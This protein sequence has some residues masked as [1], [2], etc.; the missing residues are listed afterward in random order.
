MPARVQKPTS[1]EMPGSGDQPILEARDISKSFPGVKALDRINFQLYEGEIL[2]L[3][4]ENGAGKSTLMKILSG[5]YAPDEGEIIFRGDCLT[6]SNSLEAARAGIGM[7][8]QE[9]SLLPNL[10]VAENIYL[11]RENR[12][13]K[14]GVINWKKMFAAAK[15]RLDQLG[16][17]MN[18]KA[19]THSIPFS[20]RQM[21]EIARVISL[22][23]ELQYKPI[24]ILDEPTTTLSAEEVANLFS[25]MKHLAEIKYS[26]IFISHRLEEVLEVTQK[27]VVLKD[28]RLE[29][30][31]ASTE[32]DTAKLQQLMVGREMQ[33]EYY[34]ESQQIQPESDV[35]LQINNLSKQG[36]YNN[37][38]FDLHH[39]EILG[40]T[41]V[42]G[43]GIRELT[44]TLFG[45]IAPDNGTIHLNGDVVKFR[46][47]SDAI[48]KGIG[49]IPEER[50]DEGL[51]L[52]FK[53]APN[54][55]LP[56]LN[57]ATQAGFLSPVR[58]NK[59]CNRWID[60]LNIKVPTKQTMCGNLSGGNQQKVVISKW[61]ETQVDILIMDHP[62][63]GIDVG[64]KEEV[65]A[66]I[67]QL[68]RQGISI[69]LIADSLEELIG[70]S[71]TILIMKDGEL[72]MSMPSDPGTKPNPQDLIRYMV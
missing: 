67:R 46:N 66:L 40:L 32:T 65:Y 23:D 63:R 47:P 48:N 52:Y 21:V 60:E 22:E 20:E 28:G 58:E 26:I 62:T 10:T 24:I 30:N 2:G 42:V 70:L 68:T 49:Y 11:G 59:I 53:P 39:K 12:F 56:H 36:A 71:N 14:W 1:F 64:A 34:Q 38:T 6:C 16:F 44:R 51:I 45:V 8:H 17:S 3:V 37:I 7:V 4:G 25:I 43:S 5:V 50:G 41:G 69:I 33:T 18:P 31:L 27:I 9:L 29:A 54:I 35:V 19:V 13:L 15:K 55:T 61:L 72:K 57:A